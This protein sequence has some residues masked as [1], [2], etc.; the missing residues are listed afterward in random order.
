L[1]LGA[2]IF[3]K[4]SN[5]GRNGNS[6]GDALVLPIFVMGGFEGARCCKSLKA[7]QSC[8]KNLACKKVLNQVEKVKEKTL[9]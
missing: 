5:I 1:S 9:N 8:M 3:C 2:E 6:T 7:F 4:T